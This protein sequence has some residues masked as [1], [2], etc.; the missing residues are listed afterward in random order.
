M[1]LLYIIIY[2]VCVII[3]YYIFRHEDLKEIKRNKKENRSI[4]YESSYYS[5]S[6]MFTNLLCALFFP[7]SFITYLSTKLPDKPPKWL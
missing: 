6:D 7:L 4:E 2:F 5:W 1:T 3:V